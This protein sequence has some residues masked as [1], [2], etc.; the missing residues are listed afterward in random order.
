MRF[1]FGQTA[2]VAD[3]KKAFL[4]I[5]IRNEDRDWLRFLWIDRDDRLV[6]FRMTSLPFGASCSPFILAAVLR[7]HVMRKSE[8]LPET[9]KLL[10][11]IYVDD[12]VITTAGHDEMKVLREQSIE[13]F[14]RCGMDLCKWRCSAVEIDRKWSNGSSVGEMVSV[15]GVN[16]SVGEDRLSIRN[17]IAIPDKLT[18]RL[19]VEFV[20]SV[21]DPFGLISPIVM[22]MRIRMREL[23][24]VVNA[25]DALIEPDVAEEVKTCFSKVVGLDGI[26]VSRAIGLKT[27]C[28]HLAVF[29][30]AIAKAYGAVVY[31]RDGNTG[32]FQL[33]TSRARL[34]QNRTVPELELCAARLGAE[35]INE[36]RKVVRSTNVACYTDST[37]VLQWLHQHPNRIKSLFVLNRVRRIRS[38]TPVESWFHVK[39]ADNPADLV[40]RGCSPAKLKASNLWWNGAEELSRTEFVDLNKFRMTVAVAKL[41]EENLVNHVEWKQIWSEFTIRLKAANAPHTSNDV[42]AAIWLEEQSL[43]F[44]REI[45]ALE[46]NKSVPIDS[47]LSKML[48]FIDERGLIRIASRT[49]TGDFDF[50]NPIVLEA[51]GK[52]ARSWLIHQHELLGHTGVASLMAFVGEQFFWIKLR[53]VCRNFISQCQECIEKRGKPVKVPAGMLPVERTRG[54]WPLEWILLVH[55]F[56]NETLNAGCY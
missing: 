4:Q 46:K 38:H 40:S 22:M 16:W 25:W 9:T 21:Y 56:F 12:V 31:A 53:S 52:L 48:P 14:R 30:D 8:E 26:A 17:P 28:S 27:T 32:E 44:A 34:S 37:V 49:Q 51:K 39:T 7:Y 15:L 19:V 54:F 23:L 5:R 35:L 55:S 33:L 36:V 50:D 43:A 6:A 20:N 18:R 45:S 2:A 10:N 47:K 1:R 41:S 29:C 11:R 13:L 24:P 3:L 42:F